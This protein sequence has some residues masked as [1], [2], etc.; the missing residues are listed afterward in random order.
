MQEVE[1]RPAGGLVIDKGLSRRFFDRVVRWLLSSP[2]HGL[3][4]FDR[5][6]M[7]LT[8]TGRKSGRR[9]TLLAVREA[10]DAEAR[11]A[12]RVRLPED[13]RQDL[14]DHGR[15][16]LTT[17][18]RRSGKR[19]TV[20]LSYL[21]DRD[22]YVVVGTMGGS[23]S[24]P[25]WV[26]NPRAEPRVQVGRQERE[27]RAEVAGGQERA[28]VGPDRRAQRRPLR[29]DAGEAERDFPGVV[30]APVGAVTAGTCPIVGGVTDASRL[31]GETW[32]RVSGQG[33]DSGRSRVFDTTR[34]RFG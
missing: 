10:P 24:D 29:G 18:G 15:S 32:G 19:R 33:I 23:P 26:N 4:G 8:Y 27:M 22:R 34:R 1:S 31:G 20:P 5:F 21:A 14:G 9:Y 7:L 16:L 12:A 30:L 17:T 11:G 13:G 3:F 2:L 25:G 28:A 6:G